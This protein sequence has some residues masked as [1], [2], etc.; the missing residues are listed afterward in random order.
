[1]VLVQESV[2]LQDP[3]DGWR[4]N[5]GIWIRGAIVSGVVAH[6]IVFQLKHLVDGVTISTKQLGLIVAVVMA[7]YTIIAVAIA[8]NVFF[9]IPFMTI[10]MTLPFLA[11]VGG[12]FRLFV[13]SQ[14]VHEILKQRERLAHF[15]LYLAAQTLMSVTYPAYQVLFQAAADAG[16]ELT[17]VALLPIVK[18]VMRNIIALSLSRMDDM[19][20]EAVVFSVDFFN[21][22]YIITSMQNASS[23][24]TVAIIMVADLI[25]TVVAWKSLRRRASS[26]IRE[27]RAGGVDLKLPDILDVASFL[28]RTHKS[29]SKSFAHVQIRSC[30]THQLSLENRIL[31]DDLTK[32]TKHHQF[33][34]IRSLEHVGRGSDNPRWSCVWRRTNVVQVQ[35]II[36]KT[37]EQLRPEAKDESQRLDG[38]LKVLFTAEC[39]V[40]SEYL[41]T[42]VPVLYTIYI[43]VMV[44]L[45]SA[46]YHTELS[47][48]TVDT[49][50]SKIQGILAYGLLEL[51]SFVALV[52]LMRRGCGVRSLH[53]LAFVLE[54][55]MPHIQDKLL[56]WA[57]LTLGSRV[58]HFGVDFS[59]KFDW[60]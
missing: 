1:M 6:T 36:V 25:H 27:S 43:M 32:A 37:N 38:A 12:S 8:A 19:M 58:V 7:V 54:T 44:H 33:P 5:S 57:L 15:T 21:A 20:P 39:L 48:V 41:E 49:I 24:A 17:V 16:Y 40:L 4:V 29:E 34:T 56:A 50:G 23:S 11:L 51:L 10:T 47:G 3:A 26:I 31:L 42:F 53:H 30:M 9:P 18:L 55:H 2:P 13:G 60:V 52:A 35:P 28:L 14:T 59:F 22:F 45:P 46:K